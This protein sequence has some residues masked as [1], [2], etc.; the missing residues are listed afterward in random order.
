M[1]VFQR[2][3]RWGLWGVGVWV[4]SCVDGGG[5]MCAVVLGGVGLVAA[6]GSVA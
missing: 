3:L 1:R 5:V 6:M 4:A 2:A